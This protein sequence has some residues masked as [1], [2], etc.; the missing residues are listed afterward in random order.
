MTDK[1]MRDLARMLRE[2]RR[3][4][5]RQFC[6]RCI[7]AEDYKTLGRLYARLTSRPTWDEMLFDGCL[8]AIAEATDVEL[9]CAERYATNA[10]RLADAGRDSFGRSF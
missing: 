1:E 2:E 3:Q 4:Y 8:L 10:D 9:G 7:N 5:L 6:A